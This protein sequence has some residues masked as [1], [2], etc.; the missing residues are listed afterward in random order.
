MIT[1][2]HV[3]VF[4]SESKKEAWMTASKLWKNFSKSEAIDEYKRF[5]SVKFEQRKKM[6]EVNHLAQ[7]ADLTVEFIDAGMNIPIEH[8]KSVK[9]ILESSGYNV[10]GRP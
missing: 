2:G 7:A 4:K 1:M 10:L 3:L 8:K 9:I 6:V 5:T